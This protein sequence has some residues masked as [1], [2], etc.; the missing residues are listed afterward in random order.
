MRDDAGICS[1]IGVK[2]KSSMAATTPVVPGEGGAAEP[3]PA[4]P[5]PAEPAPAEPTPA[6]EAPAEEGAAEGSPPTDAPAPLRTLAEVVRNYKPGQGGVDGGG[7]Q[8]VS[9]SDEYFYV[10][11]EALKK[12]FIDDVEFAMGKGAK[13]E[14]LVRS[15]SRVGYTDFGVNAVRLNYI[16]A[17]LREKGWKIDEITPKSHSDY[18]VASNEAREATF[19]ADRRKLDG[20]EEVSDTV[21][22]SQ[23]FNR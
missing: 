15:S 23:V 9:Q 21:K 1:C 12:G 17:S 8:V 3:A 13:R 20:G 16:S 7:F 5:A 6:A 14:V 10:Q 18:W 11:F 19:D 22:A 2:E 4:E